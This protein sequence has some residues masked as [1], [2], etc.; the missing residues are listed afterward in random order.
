MSEINPNYT[1]KIHILQIK[2]VGRD[3]SVGIANRYGLGG[4]GI[5]SRWGEIS[6]IRPDRTWG[7]PRLLC[8]GYRVL[9]VKRPGYGVDHPSRYRAEVIERVELYVYS[10]CGLS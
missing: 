3:S 2:K 1:Y 5:E 4:P 9:G 7:P 8:N 6:R 10:T